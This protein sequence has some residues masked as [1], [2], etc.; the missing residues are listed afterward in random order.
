MIKQL[1]NRSTVEVPGALIDR[2]VDREFERLSQ[3]LRERHIDPRRYFSLTGSSEE[4][5]RVP[6]TQ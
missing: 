6:P 5:W 2:E 1:L 4:E 3:T